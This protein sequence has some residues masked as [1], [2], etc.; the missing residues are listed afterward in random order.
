MMVGLG[1]RNSID[2]SITSWS[3]LMS[4]ND[5]QKKR[6]EIL[7][8]TVGNKIRTVFKLCCTSFTNIH[9]K[10]SIQ[11]PYLFL[12]RPIYSDSSQSFPRIFGSLYTSFWPQLQQ[13]WVSTIF[14]FLH[15]STYYRPFPHCNHTSHLISLTIQ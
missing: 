13:S 10:K 11:Y 12:F 2:Q 7:S 3:K 4:L 5:V 6:K 14:Q 1:S 9:L 8:R 15:Y